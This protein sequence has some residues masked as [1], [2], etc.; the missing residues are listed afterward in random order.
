MFDFSWLI[1]RFA[2]LTFVEHSIIVATD[3]KKCFFIA[4]PHNYSFEIYPSGIKGNDEAVDALGHPIED[5]N[6]LFENG[7]TYLIKSIDVSGMRK[8]SSGEDVCTMVSLSLCNIDCKLSLSSECI[9]IRVA[10]VYEFDDLKGRLAFVFVDANRVRV[11]LDDDK[12]SFCARQDNYLVS[13]TKDELQIDECSMLSRG[14]CGEII[15]IRYFDDML[16]ETTIDFDLFF[17]YLSIDFRSEDG[18]YYCIEVESDVMKIEKKE[19]H[20]RG[21]SNDK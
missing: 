7:K 10:H 8:M 1:S 16:G 17:S 20:I 9:K 6:A 21:R 11:D 19:Q 2:S 12:W 14:V 13:I 15:D 5:D 18:N 4:K 3:E